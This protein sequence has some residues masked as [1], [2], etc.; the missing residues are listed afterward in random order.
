MKPLREVIQA[1]RAKKSLSQNFLADPH[2]LNRIVESALPL[3][4]HTVIE[5]G[6]GPGGLTREIIK[7]PCK[8]LILVEQD[9]RC[10]SFLEPLAA[11]FKG[12]FSLLNQDALKVPLHTLGDPLTLDMYRSICF[13]GSNYIVEFL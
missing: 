13:D 7:H 3:E 4:S 1:L 6:P 11:H 10:L 2:I 8:E 12:R 9:E 5:I